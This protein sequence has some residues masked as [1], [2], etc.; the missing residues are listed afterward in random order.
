MSRRQERELKPIEQLHIYK[1]RVELLME[2]ELSKT[3]FGGGCKIT[4]TREQGI[5][6]ESNEPRSDLLIGFLG[7]F[8]Q[9]INNDEPIYQNKIFNLLQ[10]YLTDE[11]L[12][13]ELIKARQS[14][15]ELMARDMMSYERNG[16][17]YSPLFITDMWTK[18]ALHSYIRDPE[19]AALLKQL[20]PA[21]K[22]ILRTRFFNCI[23]KAC[24][25]INYV[26][27]VITKA[28]DEGLLDFSQNK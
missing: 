13:G 22:A 1:E 20:L 10:L 28:F 25:V 2:N 11:H 12:K 9:F 21:E 14:W 6:V 26:Y 15:D 24:S 5:E 7:V 8:R 18:D 19:K 16:K 23:T 27:I 17:D 3:G 4:F